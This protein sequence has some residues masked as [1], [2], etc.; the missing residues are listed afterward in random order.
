MN[1]I[2]GLLLDVD[3]TLIDS[4]DAHARAWKD[5]LQEFGFEVPYE[6][7][8]ECIGMGGDHLLPEVAGLDKESKLGSQIDEKRGEIFHQKYLP[9]LKAFP[10]TKELLETFKAQGLKLAIATSAS[11]DDLKALLKQAQL[12]NIVDEKTDSSDAEN[13]KPD[14]DIIESAIEKI[15]LKPQSLYM[16]GDTPYDLEAAKKAGVKSI[17]FTC[18]GWDRENLKQADFIFEGPEEMLQVLKENPSF[19]QAET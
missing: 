7:I 8:R 11:K 13:S 6:K 1:Q 15:G 3:G 9:Q 19:F 14:P 18:G 12:E 2:E 4:N 16:L 17:A 5:A 10:A